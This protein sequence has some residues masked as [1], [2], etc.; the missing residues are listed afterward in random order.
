MSKRI[1]KKIDLGFYDE[2]AEGR[3][4]F[5]ARINDFDVEVGDTIVSSE[6]AEIKIGVWRNCKGW[7]H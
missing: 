1:I 5:E 4:K 7:K 6:K 2:I 3:K